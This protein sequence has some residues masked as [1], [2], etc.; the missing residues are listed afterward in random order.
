MR[1]TRSFLLLAELYTVSPAVKVH[2]YTRKNESCPTNGSVCILKTSAAN[3][4]S[5]DA[6]LDSCAFVS[7]LMPR[8][9]G[10]SFGDGRKSTTASSTS[11]TPLFLRLLPVKTG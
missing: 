2:E 1:P 11:C 5:S 10:M 7:V 9:S 8:D 6:G 4:A 3:G